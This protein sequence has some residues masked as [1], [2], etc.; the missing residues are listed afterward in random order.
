MYYSSKEKLYQAIPK[1]HGFHISSLIRS[2][3]GTYS[4]THPTITITVNCEEIIESNR[5]DLTVVETSMVVIIIIVS[6]IVG[7]ACFMIGM[8]KEKNQNRTRPVGF[9]NPVHVIKNV[10]A[11]PV[12][13]VRSHPPSIHNYEMVNLPTYEPGGNFHNEPDEQGNAE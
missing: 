13:T 12:P 3:A 9:E 2:I 11:T 10:D 8:H 1:S 6:V 7:F 4:I 5:R